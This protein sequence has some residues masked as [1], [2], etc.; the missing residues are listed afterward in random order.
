MGGRLGLRHPLTGCA[1][2]CAPET[3]GQRHPLTG[4]ALAC[5]PETARAAV[6]A[7]LTETVPVLTATQTENG[8]DSVPETQTGNGSDSAVP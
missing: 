5:A 2:A 7:I 1:L 6:P 4:C 8:I 3:A